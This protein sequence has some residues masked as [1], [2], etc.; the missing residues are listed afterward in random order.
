M[1]PREINIRISYGTM[2]NLAELLVYAARHR[3]WDIVR[4][5]LW[6]MREDRRH[7]TWQPRTIGDH[8]MLRRMRAHLSYYHRAPRPAPWRHMQS[9]AMIRRDARRDQGNP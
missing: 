6:V 3:K 5:G 9:P 4:R 7:G 1:P 2:V 8:I